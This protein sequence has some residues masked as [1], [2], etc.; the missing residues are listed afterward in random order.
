M[1]LMRWGVVG[2]DADEQLLIIRLATESDAQKVIM[3]E[4]S[5]LTR[6]LQRD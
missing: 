3:G 4:K 2:F 5:T 6:V 1:L